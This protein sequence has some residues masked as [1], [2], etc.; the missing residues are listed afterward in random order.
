MTSSEAR[1]QKTNFDIAA[2]AFQQGAEDVSTA[3]TSA[4]TIIEQEVAMDG[5][6]IY[7]A[8]GKETDSLRDATKYRELLTAN[9]AIISKVDELIEAIENT[10]TSVDTAMD[11][12]IT[13]LV[14]EEN[15][16]NEQEDTEDA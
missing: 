3:C 15:Q 7:N 9:N 6:T 13:A 16:A 1:T 10:K 4:A 14:N 2:I 5:K 11:L 8:K 12:E